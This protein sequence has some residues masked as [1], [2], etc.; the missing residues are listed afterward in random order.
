MLFQRYLGGLILGGGLIALAFLWIVYSPPLLFQIVGTVLVFG[1][2]LLGVD[3][4]SDTLAP[5]ERE[6]LDGKCRDQGHSEG[7]QLQSTRLHQPVSLAYV[8]QQCD[9]PLGR[10]ADVSPL[11]DVKCQHC[12]KWFNIH[13]RQAT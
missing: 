3:M 4:I 2:I 1:P 9:A 6:A 13:G 11:G 8:C 12:G 7:R 5:D 10:N